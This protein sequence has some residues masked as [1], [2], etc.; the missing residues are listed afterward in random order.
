MTN[1]EIEKRFLFD[2]QIDR[3][4]NNSDN[5]IFVIED[6][7]NYD[8]INKKLVKLLKNIEDIDPSIK[9][10]FKGKCIELRFLR[11]SMFTNSDDRQWNFLPDYIKEYKLEWLMKK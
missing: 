2:L 11:K 1:E 6:Y 10:K 3:F 7:I 4:G 5:I 9:S 8:T